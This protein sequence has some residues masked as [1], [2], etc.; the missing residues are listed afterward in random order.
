MTAPDLLGAM[1]LVGVTPTIDVIVIRPP[2]DSVVKCK[3]V[4]REIVVGDG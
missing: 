4:E 3:L 1:L 2:P